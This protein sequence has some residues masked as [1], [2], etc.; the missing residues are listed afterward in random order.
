MQNKIKQK[1]VGGICGLVTALAMNTSNAEETPKT[2]QL[3]KYFPS[4]EVHLLPTAMTK[5]EADLLKSFIKYEC[6]AGSGITDHGVY[7]KDIVRD[8]CFK[9]G[10]VEYPSE[11]LKRVCTNKYVPPRS[12]RWGNVDGHYIEE[13]ENRWVSVKKKETVCEAHDW[14]FL[15]ELYG[16]H[17][18]CSGV[19]ATFPVN[20]EGNFT[21]DRAVITVLYDGSK[22]Y[23]ASNETIKYPAHTFE[24]IKYFTDIVDK[25]YCHP[26]KAKRGKR[27]K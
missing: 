21:G 8:T 5:E 1:L 7:C 9:R 4:S 12:S 13:C 27:S 3:Q 19:I 14:K 11:E 10:T 24:E 22:D 25:Y 18:K 17:V 26:P 15:W 6:P 2:Y 20:G 16:D 23:G